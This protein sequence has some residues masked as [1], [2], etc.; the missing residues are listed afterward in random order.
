[1]T[2]RYQLPPGEWHAF[3]VWV[4]GVYRGRYRG[5]S[6]YLVR[7]RVCVARGVSPSVVTVELAKETER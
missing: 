6:A 3:S 5:K 4:S 2:N 1:M 7:E